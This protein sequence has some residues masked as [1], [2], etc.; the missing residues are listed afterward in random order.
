MRQIA[1]EVDVHVSGAVVT[2]LQLRSREVTFGPEDA[3]IPLPA[4]ADG[5]RFSLTFDGM[6][7]VFTP[8]DG[9]VRWGEHALDRPASLG[10]RGSLELGGAAVYFRLIEGGGELRLWPEPLLV[11]GLRVGATSRFYGTR[12]LFGRG[13]G[14]A[15]CMWDGVRRLPP[16]LGPNLDKLRRLAGE[17]LPVEI[18]SYIARELGRRFA[19]APSG[20]RLSFAPARARLDW[21]GAVYD[22]ALPFPG[23]FAPPARHVPNEEPP[24]VPP[25]GAPA[26]AWLTTEALRFLLGDRA[27]AVEASSFNAVMRHLDSLGPVSEEEAGDF[28]CALFAEDHARDRAVLD[29]LELA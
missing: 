26:A 20:A 1:I 19:A 11:E 14:G 13:E 18:A 24:I 16:R 23:V 6:E 28:V 17:H 9:H 7:L 2:R 25:H 27:H 29:E 4:A 21:S 15:L 3:D 22:L 12:L 5:A 10:R 8:G